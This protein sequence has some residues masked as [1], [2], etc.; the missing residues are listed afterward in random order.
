MNEGRS[1]SAVPKAGPERS[2]PVQTVPEIVPASPKPGIQSQQ[3]PSRS[4]EE[5]I[6]VRGFARKNDDGRNADRRLANH[7][8]QPLG[9]LTAAG[10]PK[11]TP[12]CRLRECRS[13]LDCPRNCPCRTLDCGSWQ[14]LVAPSSSATERSGSFVNEASAEL[15]ESSE[16]ARLGQRPLLRKWMTPRDVSPAAAALGAVIRVHRF[17]EP[18]HSEHRALRPPETLELEGFRGILEECRARRRAGR[19]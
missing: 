9:H 19:V 6:E 15:A 5:V 12:A 17:S 14:R 2:T 11:Y 1:F 18:V 4:I 16:V 13:G 3:Q 10:F 7:R 8:L